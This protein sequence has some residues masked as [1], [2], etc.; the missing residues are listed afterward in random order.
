MWKQSTMTVAVALLMSAGVG[1]PQSR[2]NAAK[3]MAVHSGTTE[4]VGLAGGP[5]VLFY[6]DFVLGTSAYQAALDALGWSFTMVVDPADFET[7]LQTGA[8]T[9]VIA[10]HQNAGGESVWEDD[11]AAWIVA[12]PDG[13]VIVSDWRVVEPAPPYLAGLG[14]GYTQTTNLGMMDGVGGETLDGLAGAL[15]NPGWGTFSYGVTGGTTI[16]TDTPG[17]GEA[18]VARSGCVF[19]NGFLSDTFLNPAVGRDV[20]MREL[21]CGTIGGAFELIGVTGDGADTPESLFSISTDDASIEFICG[22][23]RGDDG[24]T[25]AFNGTDGRLYHA[26]GHVGPFDPTTLDGVIFETVD[27]IGNGSSCATTDIDI[28]TTDLIDEE[29]QAI[30]WW[31]EENVFLWKQDHGADYPLFRVTTDGVATVIGDLD[32]QAK[33]LAFAALPAA[34]DGIGL[35]SVDK[36]SAFLRIIDPTDASTIDEIPMILTTGVGEILG[37]NG[38]ATHP[39]TGELWGI[40]RVELPSGEVQRLLGVIDP[41]GEVVVVGALGDKFAGLAFVTIAG[42]DDCNGNGIPDDVETMPLYQLDEDAQA[43]PECDEAPFI[44]PFIRY[45][46]TT[47]TTGAFGPKMPDYFFCGLYVGVFDVFYRYAP[48]W[49]GLAFVSVEGPPVDFVYGVYDDCPPSPECLIDCNEIDHFEIVFEAEKGKTYWIRIAAQFFQ[50][51]PFELYLVGP[52]VTFNP[53]D[54]NGN[55]IPDECECLADVD[56]DGFITA[57]DVARIASLIGTS[58]DGCPEDVDG[59][60][61]VDLTDLQIVFALV[62]EECPFGDGGT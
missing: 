27:G 56:G 57:M 5:N 55:G 59:D 60:G 22:L 51:A 15:V 43:S 3:L 52:D 23:G 14:F 30:V 36:G 50:E 32:H 9:H 58:C 45:E 37:G 38:L 24:E 18:I 49:D 20:M 39:G 40:I 35:Y 11:L 6:E 4:V 25:I 13:V 47:V 62:G 53:T 54:C 12:N 8:Y 7:E 26:S 28:S 34:G 19:F 29:A 1:P 31:P 17:T 41:F 44:G 2:Q 48:A 46:S 16:A 33:G 10:A 61:E 42:G 21:Q